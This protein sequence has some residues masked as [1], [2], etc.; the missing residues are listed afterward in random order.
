M[1]L[2]APR[3]LV[4]LETEQPPHLHL[5]SQNSGG[6]FCRGAAT[7]CCR[8]GCVSRF[9]PW[10]GARR[11]AWPASQPTLAFLKGNQ[12]RRPV[13]KPWLGRSVGVA[14]KGSFGRANARFLLRSGLAA[15]YGVRRRRSCS[16]GWGRALLFFFPSAK[17]Q[18]RQ[19]TS[20]T[21]AITT[22]WV[23]NGD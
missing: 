13:A 5:P 4:R 6:T 3:D 15:A 19:R 11:G 17:R 21:P 8:V 1:R 14:H 18:S 10:R 2:L 7:S 16:P 23:G 22:R 12:A 9:R 20:E